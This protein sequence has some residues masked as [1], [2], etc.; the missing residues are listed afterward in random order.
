MGIQEWIQHYTWQ[1]ADLI[2]LLDNN[3]TDNG[4]YIAEQFSNVI[5]V[6]APKNNA[7]VENYY[8]GLTEILKHGVDF[9]AVVDLDEYMFGKVML[10]KQC[11][12]Y[13]D[14]L[15]YSQ[16]SVNWAMFGSSGFVTQPSSIR[17]SFIRRKKELQ[18]NLKSIWKC[19]DLIQ[20]FTHKSHVRGKSIEDNTFIQLN[21][22]IIQ[23]REYFA[24]VKMTRGD[25]CNSQWA[26]ARTWAYFK[27][28]DF[29]EIDDTL[30]KDCMKNLI[31]V[32]PS[33]IVQ[34]YLGI[35]EYNPNSFISR[36]SY[37][38]FGILVVLWIVL[39]YG[40]SRALTLWCSLHF[41]LLESHEHESQQIQ[42]NKLLGKLC[43][44]FL[45]LTSLVL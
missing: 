37:L 22:Y 9:V 25:V 15:G 21:H 31:R 10:L 11:V 1:G 28:N 18:T 42:E 23:S 17:A 3:S 36:I 6:D 34:N 14:K 27:A 35:F 30:L 29:D 45:T 8:L 19:K 41:L 20:M 43:F 38:P 44:S 40:G 33:P 2:V 32:S 12:A 26:N 7:Q 16:I 4:R 5:V 24:T 13:Y 39:V